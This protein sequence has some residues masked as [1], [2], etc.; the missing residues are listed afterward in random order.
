MRRA[1]EG[2]G[3][4]GGRREE[5]EGRE[6]EHGGVPMAAREL[7]ALM[8]K[9]GVSLEQQLKGWVDLSKGRRGEGG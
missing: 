3:G 4:G 9:H 5:E 7:S 2:G 1:T 8:G 6:D